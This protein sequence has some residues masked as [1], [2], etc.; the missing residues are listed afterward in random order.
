M[1]IPI[2]YE[3]DYV[4]VVNKPAGLVVHSDGKTKEMTLSDW[5][6]ER[7]PNMKDVGEPVVLSSGE[8]I[9]RPGIVH[10]IDRDT[11]GVL[12][13]AKTQDSF[14]FIKE[15]FKNRHIKKEYRAFVYGL[16]KKD[17]EIINREIGRSTKDFRLW[18]AQR[19]ARGT[20]REAITEYIVLERG[21]EFSYLS[22]F[23]KTGRTHQ[24]RVHLKAI[25]HPV[26]NDKLY[27]PKREAG[28]GL[29]RLALHAFNIE[30]EIPNT[31]IKFFEAPLPEDFKI[32]L[33]YL[34]NIAQG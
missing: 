1:T 15:Q 24:I 7:Y 8:T 4:I 5:I 6:I 30:L 3:D 17:K 9:L 11:S 28:L 18:S 32:A 23:P 26:V 33:E 2:I 14:L 21:K 22:V 29:S 27:A 31:G 10:R 34:H 19:G 20:L 25:N 12:V 13:I 16:V